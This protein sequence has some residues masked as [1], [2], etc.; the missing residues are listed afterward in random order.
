MP[1]NITA[2]RVGVMAELIGAASLEPMV[3]AAVNTLEASGFQTVFVSAGRSHRD[4]LTAWEIQARSGCDGLIV[5][6]DCLSNDQL[7]RLISTRKNVVLANLFNTQIGNLAANHLLASGHSRLALVSGPGHRFCSRHII[8][9]FVKQLECSVNPDVELQTLESTL[10]EEGGSNAMR[11]LLSARKPPTAVFFQNDRMAVGALAECSTQ[12]TRV[13]E[14]VSI[15]GC[16]DL[17]V[18][19]CTQPALSTLRQP[20][21]CIGTYT[22]QRV[23]NMI[24]NV[25][26]R[27]DDTVEAERAKPILVCRAS[28]RDQNGRSLEVDSPIST[29]E[30][31]CLKWA[32]KGKTSWEIS[33]I[34]GVTESTIIYHLRNAT[35]K[36]NAAN[37]LHAVA[38]ALKASIIDI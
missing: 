29:R 30:R 26:A 10:D 15:L 13:P 35:R 31:E 34:L 38:K 21:S 27:P 17:P 9:G 24:E 32:A 18:S 3:D 28:V 6:S 16:G 36:L 2:R 11:L 4:E 33:Q 12:G 23:M 5:H 37:R 25:V 8:E 1:L 22:A 19:A 20:L 7:A 14:D